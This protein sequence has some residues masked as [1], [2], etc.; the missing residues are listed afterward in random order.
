MTHGSR[1]LVRTPEAGKLAAVLGSEAVV[2]PAGDDDVYITG[3]DAV[4]VG[5]A[6]QRAGIAIY[7]LVTEGPDL[8]AAFLKLTAGK[9]AIR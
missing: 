7:Q 6:A 9:A 3:V 5:D 1:I 2:T 4:A 8:E